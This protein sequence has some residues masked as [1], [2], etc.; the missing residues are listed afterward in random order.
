MNINHF[1]GTNT[2]RECPNELKRNGLIDKLSL[3]CILNEWLRKVVSRIIYWTP[4][5]RDLYW[6]NQTQKYI[7]DKKA[8][9]FCQTINLRIIYFLKTVSLFNTRYSG[10]NIYKYVCFLSICVCVFYD[11]Q[12]STSSE[13]VI[14]FCMTLFLYLFIY[15]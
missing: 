7:T 3:Q 2:Y 15:A 14:L 12:F 9:I 11:E 6:T 5:L 10:T 4:V 13:M 1:C 8:N